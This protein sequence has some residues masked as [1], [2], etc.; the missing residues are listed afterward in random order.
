M[1]LSNL[2][3]STTEEGRFTYVR[4]ICQK[5][6]GTERVEVWCY[7][8]YYLVPNLRERENIP[9]KI[10]KGVL[11]SRI[12]SRMYRNTTGS[13]IIILYQVPVTWEITEKIRSGIRSLSCFN[14]GCTRP[15]Y[16]VQVPT[17]SYKYKYR[18]RGLRAY[19]KPSQ[20]TRTETTKILLL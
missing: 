8:Y 10:E 5:Q 15:W 20:R 3:D 7:C 2:P 18:I 4:G 11:M 9:T 1:I 12:L 6:A 19:T 14:N 13:I 17:D 16:K